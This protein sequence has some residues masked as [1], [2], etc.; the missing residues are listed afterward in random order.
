LTLLEGSSSELNMSAFAKNWIQGEEVINEVFSQIYPDELRRVSSS[1]LRPAFGR[2]LLYSGFR[3]ITTT[4][5]AAAT[6]SAPEASQNGKI[7]IKDIITSSVIGEADG[8]LVETYKSGICIKFLIP[9]MSLSSSGGPMCPV[10][11]RNR[12]INGGF[13]VYFKNSATGDVVGKL[14]RQSGEAADV[15]FISKSGTKWWQLASED[16]SFGKGTYLT[17][18]IT[19]FNYPPV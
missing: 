19:T 6:I 9:V 17:T 5:A 14:V 10:Q 7:K 11:T 2:K 15:S 1:R 12:L 4:A 3:L 18:P 16:T 8:C 13:R